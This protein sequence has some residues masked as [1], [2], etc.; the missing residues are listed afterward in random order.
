M[1]LRASRTDGARDGRIKVY[2]TWIN[3]G[4]AESRHYQFYV[5]DSAVVFSYPYQLMLL[6][7][8]NKL[9]ML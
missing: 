5:S 8:V 9:F 1:C 4:R 2:I 3:V 6:L 7:V